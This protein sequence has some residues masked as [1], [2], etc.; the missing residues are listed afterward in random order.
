MNNCCKDIHTE[1]PGIGCGCPCHTDTKSGWEEEFDKEFIT[2]AGHVRYLKNGNYYTAPIEIKAF[3]AKTREAAKEEARAE[4]LTDLE[5]QLGIGVSV[6][7]IVD[8]LHARRK[9]T[10]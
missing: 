8:W 2:P 9:G 7:N 5:A 10:N 4:V 6:D 3:I 1:H